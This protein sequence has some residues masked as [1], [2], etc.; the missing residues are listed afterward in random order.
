[1]YCSV[2][3]AYCGVFTSKWFINPNRFKY[4][5][6]LY[7]NYSNI[8]LDIQIYKMTCPCSIIKGD[9][10]TPV[11]LA[12]SQGSLE[13]VK[14]MLDGQPDLKDLVLASRDASGMTP[15]H[16]TA[17]MDKTD[18]ACYLLQQVRILSAVH[19]LK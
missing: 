7:F 2:Y 5:V 16:V 18:I 19:L 8:M 17:L 11:H 6:H 10:S 3:A 9:Q 15:L 13:M 14:A 12:S 1:M 4:T